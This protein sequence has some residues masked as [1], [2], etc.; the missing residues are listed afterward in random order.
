MYYTLSMVAGSDCL[1]LAAK[2]EIE[3]SR[4]KIEILIN[5][6]SI[7]FLIMLYYATREKRK[8]FTAIGRQVVQQSHE[9]HRFFTTLSST[10]FFSIYCWITNWQ[11]HLIT[12]PISQQIV[13]KTASFSPLGKGMVVSFP[14]LSRKRYHLKTAENR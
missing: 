2:V 4:T 10:L 1:L 13:R 5:W 7:R 3:V 8:R 14:I 11:Y 12:F 6:K 9:W